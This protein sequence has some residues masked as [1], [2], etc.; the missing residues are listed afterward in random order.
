MDR[1]EEALS[2]KARSSASSPLSMCFF[3]AH[4][5]PSPG[6]L[7]PLRFARGSGGVRLQGV[8][9]MKGAAL[10]AFVEAR[11]EATVCAAVEDSLTSAL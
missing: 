3:G 1:G 11:R 2:A 7:Y 9:S 5:L 6:G 8:S 10:G 4:F